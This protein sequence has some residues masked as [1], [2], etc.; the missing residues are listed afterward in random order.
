MVS[1]VIF[2]FFGVLSI[3]AHQAF[4][5]KSIHDHQELDRIYE[6]RRQHDLGFITVEE[7]LA[8]VGRVTHLEPTQVLQ[9]MHSE[10]VVNQQLVDY[11]RAELKPHCQ[12]GLL[13]NAAGDLRT[14]ISPTLLRELFDDLLI[15][16]DV[17]MIKPDPHIFELACERLDVEPS[18]TVMIDDVGENCRAAEAVGMRAIRYDSFAQFKSELARLR[19]A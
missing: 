9:Q 4:L 12:I 5:E 18:E 15:S 7:Y 3:R 2:D 19:D 10:R 14:F 16:A 6:L 13:S 1:A 17:G 8:E 11:I